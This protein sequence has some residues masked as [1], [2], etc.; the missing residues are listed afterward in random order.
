PLHVSRVQTFP[1]SVQA[2]PFGFFASAGQA[3]DVPVQVSAASH[4]PAAAR[5]LVV[6]G[7]NAS[8]GQAAAVPVHFSATSHTPTAA[9]Q[10]VAF[11]RNASAGQVVAAPLQVSATSQAPAAARQTVPLGATE[12]VPTLPATL[13]AWQAPVQAVSQ[14]TPLTQK[15]VV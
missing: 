8:T 12:Q 11:D 13:Q 15:P 2:V 5:Q 6:A 3:F 14:Q 7:A 10:V 4:S 1:S 9:R